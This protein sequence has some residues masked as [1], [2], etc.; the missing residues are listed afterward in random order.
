MALWELS[1]IKLLRR[2]PDD[3]PAV[4]TRHYRAVDVNGN[5]WSRIFTHPDYLRQCQLCGAAVVH[6]WVPE[7]SNVIQLDFICDEHFDMPEGER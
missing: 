1:D 2:H 5:W 6:G 7:G 4:V 3:P